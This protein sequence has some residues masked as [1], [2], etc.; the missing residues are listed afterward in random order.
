MNTSK[1]SNPSQASAGKDAASNREHRGAPAAENSGPGT[2]GNE[3]G[4]IDGATPGEKD[5][6]GRDVAERMKAEQG[7]LSGPSAGH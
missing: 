7:T 5:S 6:K 4:A 1:S 2:P 3:A